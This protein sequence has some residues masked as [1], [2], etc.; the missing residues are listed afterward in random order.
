M[1]LVTDGT[2][3]WVEVRL[4]GPKDDVL[5]LAHEMTQGR[6]VRIDSGCVGPRADGNHE[7]YMTVR[8]RAGVKSLDPDRLLTPG[9]VAR[10]FR[11]DSKTVARWAKEGRLAS[12][13]TLGGHRRFKQRDVQA[14]LRGDAP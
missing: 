3:G 6:E 8:G 9:Q 13:K 14:F 12:T 10:V 7:R 1:T 5:H 11:V 2:P 4:I